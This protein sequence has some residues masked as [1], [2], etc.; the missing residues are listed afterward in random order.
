MF[1][2]RTLPLTVAQIRLVIEAAVRLGAQAPGRHAASEIDLPL[3]A[4]PLLPSPPAAGT[5]SPAQRAKWLASPRT[6]ALA[7]AYDAVWSLAEEGVIASLFLIWQSGAH[8]GNLSVSHGGGTAG[9]RVRVCPYT[10]DAGERARAYDRLL[11]DLGLGEVRAEPGADGRLRL[12]ARRPGAPPGPG[13]ERVEVMQPQGPVS[14]EFHSRID[15]AL[16]IRGVAPDVARA[17]IE[18]RLA[19]D[20]PSYGSASLIGRAPEAFDRAFTRAVALTGPEG[21]RIDVTAPDTWVVA[22]LEPL[23]EAEATFLVAAFH[24]KTAGGQVKGEVGTPDSED[25]EEGLLRMHLAADVPTY[26]AL[27]EIE[28]AI[29]AGC[30]IHP[31][32]DPTPL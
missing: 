1:E 12:S 9:A 20:P 7:L 10:Q 4:V 22:N 3:T 32:F 18:P 29:E 15:T 2:A 6:A 27:A 19:A 28:R 5:S 14:V 30:G 21:W 23:V 17:L 31:L 25:G 16:R 13:S 11:D 24:L 26:E 8:A